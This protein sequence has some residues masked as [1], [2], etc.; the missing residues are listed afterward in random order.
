MFKKSQ[1]PLILTTAFLD[2]LG[3][4]LF[5]PILP[6]IISAFWVNPSWSGYTQAVYAIGMFT[7]GLFFG[8]LSDK[9]GRKKLLS[10]TS[11]LNL[12]AFIIMLVSIGSLQI[13]GTATAA[14]S[15][16]WGDTTSIGLAHLRDAFQNIPWIFLIF[17]LA[18]FIGGLGGAGYGVIGAYI[19]DISKPSDRVKNM[20]LMGAAFG[21]AFLIGPA[22]SGILA[23]LGLSTH[24]IVILGIVII[25]VNVLLIWLML[26]EPKKHI[27]MMHHEHAGKFHF[28]NIVITLLALSFGSAL[29]FAAIQSMS[30]QFY[31]DKFHF[32]PAE[33]GYT[34][35]MVG[36]VSV[37]YQGWLVKY[38]RKHLNEISMIHFAFFLLLIGFIGFSLNQSPIWLFFWVAVFPLGMWSFQPSLGSLLAK[39]AGKEVGKA[40]GY[41]TSMQSVGN[42]IGP[43]LAGSLY[44]FPGSNLP[45]LVSAGVFWILFLISFFIK[46]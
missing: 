32:T 24:M 1:L 31:A 42:I 12:S 33:I 46:K 34:M 40:M 29:A 45:F 30:G 38:V 14:S 44:A 26:E 11:I 2:I 5:I 27:E 37:L 35:A 28:S 25:T 22:I 8:R 7:G 4:S 16:L 41:N 23:S 10:Y 43:I 13:D 9:Y 19:S 18:R 36:L 21:M 3:L 17:L 20:G 15:S 6:D 39:N